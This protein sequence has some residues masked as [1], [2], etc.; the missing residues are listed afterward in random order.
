MLEI[1]RYIYSIFSERTVR[2][3]YTILQFG[4]LPVPVHYW[5]THSIAEWYSRWEDYMI[6]TYIHVTH[7]EYKNRM[8]VEQRDR[9]GDGT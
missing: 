8:R 9:L 1:C 3:E 2:A 6:Q 4:A 5:V 7:V